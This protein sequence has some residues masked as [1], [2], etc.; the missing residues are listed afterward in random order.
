MTESLYSRNWHN[1][2]T[3]L[4]FNKKRI[5]MILACLRFICELALD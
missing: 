5:K 4:Y 1:I 3:Q 2:V